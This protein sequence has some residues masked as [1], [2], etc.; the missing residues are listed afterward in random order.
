MIAVQF[1]PPQFRIKKRG[2]ERYIFDAIRK[3]W[4]VLT[5]EE[6]VRQN[7]VAYFT[8]VLHYPKDSIAV[9]KGI[10]LNGLKK[11]FDILV[12]NKAHQPYLMVECKSPDV[13]LNE[14]VLQQVLRYNIALPVKWV[15]LTNGHTTLAWKKE[16]DQLV[17]ANELPLWEEI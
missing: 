3:R 16:T 7:I 14:D 2:E 17:L 13:A 10:T 6:W 9:E 5:E 4:L 1:P 15:V 8:A 12:Y 11:R